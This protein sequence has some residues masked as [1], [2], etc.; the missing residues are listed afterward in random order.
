MLIINFKDYHQV[1]GPKALELAQKLLEVAKNYPAVTVGFAPPPAELAEVAA[2]AAAQIWAQHVDPVASGK[3]TGYL[4][5]TDAK[6]SGAIGTFLNHSEHPLDDETIKKTADLARREGLKVLIFARG[7]KE[8]KNFCNLSPDLIAYEPP[9]LIGGT[10]SVSQAKPEIIQEAV[11]A[12]GNIPLLVG[13]GIHERG[14]IETALALGA[15]GAV[16]SSAVVTAKDPQT[17]YSNL[18]SGF[19][20]RG[21]SA[22]DGKR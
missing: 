3:H 8:V 4:S 9:E 6:A 2:H 19:P 17:V 14:D 22:L 21:G 12:S 11:E 20:A 16:V 18:L 13:A 10:T 1:T 15:I 5:P 7:P